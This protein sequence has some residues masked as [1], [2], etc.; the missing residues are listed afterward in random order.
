MRI[1]LIFASL[2]TCLHE[3]T[4]HIYVV[5]IEFRHK[6]SFYDRIRHW[7]ELFFMKWQTARAEH[8]RRFIAYK[9]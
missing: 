3:C 5:F 6:M 1:F 8:R 4:L 7:I 9:S 2:C